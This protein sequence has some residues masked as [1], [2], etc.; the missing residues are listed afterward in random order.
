MQRPGRSGTFALFAQMAQG[1]ATMQSQ[2]EQK[3][4]PAARRKERRKRSL[5]YQR[6]AEVPSFPITLRSMARGPPCSR[7]G[8]DDVRRRYY[9]RHQREKSPM[10]R[11]WRQ[12]SWSMAMK[13]D[14]TTKAASSRSAKTLRTHHHTPT[15]DIGIWGL[16]PSGGSEDG[17][18]ER[19][20][21]SSSTSRPRTKRGQST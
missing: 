20:R 5:T 3:K 21:C 17:D 16:P 1:A 13:G 18:P 4:S 6:M 15:E 12:V 2:M 19:G 8:A 14:A 10:L 9:H 7:L 11:L